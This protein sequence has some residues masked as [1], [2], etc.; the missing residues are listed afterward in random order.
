MSELIQL[1]ANELK[2]LVKRSVEGLGFAPGDQLSAGIKAASAFQ[3]GLANSGL[4]SQAL[5]AL[6]S[7]IKAPE[8]ILSSDQELVFDAHGQSA[9]VQ[10]E[11]ALGLGLAHCSPQ[12]RVRN[13]VAPA[14]AVPCMMNWL[15]QPLNQPQAQQ[16]YALYFTHR[17]GAQRCVLIAADGQPLGLYQPRELLVGENELMLSMGQ[18]DIDGVMI[19]DGADLL[20]WRERCLDQGVHVDASVLARLKQMMHASLV[21]ETEASRMGAGPD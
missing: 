4:L 9:L 8:L 14:F 10:V 18:A 7:R 16:C 2:F 13:L 17:S 3:L 12:V 6:S 11:L 21:P 20:G 1:S 19:T 5:D 15:S